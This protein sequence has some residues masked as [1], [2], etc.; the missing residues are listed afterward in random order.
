[1]EA[2]RMELEVTRF[3]LPLTIENA[4]TLI[5]ER[6]GRQGVKLELDLDERLREFTGDER[7]VRQILLNLLSNA[8]KF[9]PEGGRIGIRAMPV[10]GGVEIAVSDTGLHRQIRKQSSRSSVRSARTGRASRKGQAS[11]SRWRGNSSSCTVA[12]SG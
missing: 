5:R 1:V 2:G 7:K 9:T 12:G 6:A 11:D 4:L 10:D 8:V 3:D